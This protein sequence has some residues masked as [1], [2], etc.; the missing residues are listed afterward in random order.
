MKSMDRKEFFKE[1]IPIYRREPWTF[2]KEVVRFEPDDWQYDVMKDIVE[3]THVSVRS[4]QGVGKTALEAVLALW[5]LTVFPFPKVVATA[6]TR[7][8]LHDILWAEIAKWQSRS[9]LLES[10][11][12]WT[13]TK[14]YMRKYEERWFATARTATKPENMQGFHEDNMLFIVDE[15]S[16]VADPIME[17]ILGTLSGPNNKL[18]MFG[19]PTRTS[20]VFYDSHNRDRHHYRTHKVSSMDSSRTS[21]KNI[22][23]ILDKYGRDSDVARVRIFGEFPRA[24]ADTFI[25]LEIVELAV[26]TDYRHSEQTTIGDLGVD[27]ARFGDDETVI[28][29]R[30]DNYVFP[31]KTYR[32][33]DTTATTGYVLKSA[34][35]MMKENEHLKEIYIKVDDSG[36]GGGVT[37]QLREQIKEQSLPFKVFPVINNGKADDDEHYENVGTEQW[38]VLRDVLNENFSKH[39][40]GKPVEIHLPDDEKLVSQLT[41]RKYRMTS[42]GKIALERKEDMKERGLQSPDRADAVVL[43]FYRPKKPTVKLFKGGL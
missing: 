10:L 2:A 9:P 8:Q 39:M 12:K 17:A 37:D 30:I 28:A 11:L 35:D 36:V 23:M 7:Q 6:P 26:N 24:E 1:K 14:I 15:A 20:G 4:G 40:Q 22:E 41:T 38:A 3:H 33:L 32:K 18:A 25:P 13:K 43:A 42:R 19:N 29:S 21:K 27:V 34:K 5:F 31:L 16:G